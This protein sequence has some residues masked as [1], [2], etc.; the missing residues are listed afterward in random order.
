MNFG[1][2]LFTRFLCYIGGFDERGGLR[3][4]LILSRSVGSVG[5]IFS[6]FFMYCDQTVLAEMASRC[7]LTLRG[8]EAMKG[9][10]K[11]C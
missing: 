3:I 7:A 5:P 4:I 10:N 9:P 6:Q 1:Y 8:I 11:K 2:L